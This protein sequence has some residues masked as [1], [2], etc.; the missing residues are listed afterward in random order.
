VAFPRRLVSGLA[1]ALGMLGLIVGPASAARNPDLIQIL[2]STSYPTA[3]NP[4]PATID[5]SGYEGTLSDVDVQLFGLSH[6]FPND[7][8]VLLVSPTGV[9]VMLLSDAGGGSPTGPVDPLFDDA[10]FDFVP[11]NGPLGSGPYDPTNYAGQDPG[12][13]MPAR[14]RHLRTRPR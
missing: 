13:V 3:A 7:I 14:R 6:T 12:E 11:E 2:D 4:Y 8:D 10:S 1:V 5:I 9:A